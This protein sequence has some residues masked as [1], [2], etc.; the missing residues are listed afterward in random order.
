MRIRNGRFQYFAAACIIIIGLLTG[1]GKQKVDYIKVDTEDEEEGGLGLMDGVKDKWKDTVLCTGSDGT[2]HSIEISIIPSI[3]NVEQMSVVE[4]KE[5]EFSPENKQRVAEAFFGNEVYSANLRMMI[6]KKLEDCE[7]TISSY[8]QRLSE[9]GYSESDIRLWEEEKK[10][11]EEEYAALCEKLEN[12]SESLEK[13]SGYED[14]SYIG[15][16]GDAYYELRFEEELGSNNIY[17]EEEGRKAAAKSRKISIYPAVPLMSE[18][19]LLAVGYGCDDNM[20]EEYNCGEAE[21]MLLEKLV[22]AGF[23]YLCTDTMAC[24]GGNNR[25]TFDQIREQYGTSYVFSLGT[26]VDDIPFSRFGSAGDYLLHMSWSGTISIP[27]LTD[28]L[29]ATVY[30]QRVFELYYWDPM[31]VVSVVPNVSMLSLDSVKKILKDEIAKDSS[32]ADL[33]GESAIRLNKL[34]LIYFPVADSG[35]EGYR[36]YVPAWRLS[37]SGAYYGIMINAMDGSVIQLQREL[38]IEEG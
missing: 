20:I 31:E 6:E 2:E 23:G 30:D 35:K 16:I 9:A 28:D 15:K 33:A 8:E 27:E 37:N 3:P 13:T 36:S 7:E 25:G 1:C 12:A 22:K 32:L 4:V 34:E 18:E 21:Q 14:D 10:Q 11:F 38:G 24:V 26:G 19:E 29:M 5:F 17:F